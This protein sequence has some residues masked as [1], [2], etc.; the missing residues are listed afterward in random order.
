MG[1]VGGAR[2]RAARLGRLILAGE[3]GINAA[4]QPCHALLDYGEGGLHGVHTPLQ[5]PELPTLPRQGGL[6]DV[7]QKAFQRCDPR[8]TRQ[9]AAISPRERKGRRGGVGGPGREGSGGLSGD[10]GGGALPVS[11]AMLARSVS[12]LA[13]ASRTATPHSASTGSS[14]PRTPVRR[15]STLSA[16]GASPPP[17]AR[18]RGSGRGSP[19]GG[20]G[21]GAGIETAPEKEGR[22]G[23]GEGAR[24]SRTPRQARRRLRQGHAPPLAALPFSGAKSLRATG[25]QAGGGGGLR[26]TRD[27]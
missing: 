8:H 15:R 10:G 23:R 4:I 14:A 1:S 26:A 18:V 16:A 13:C 20:W 7:L 17:G 3:Q 11:W 5:V 25:T 19:G 6:R 27:A 22:R 12:W 2:S 9:G 21:G 24:G